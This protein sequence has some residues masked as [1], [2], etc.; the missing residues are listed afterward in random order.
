M[1]RTQCSHLWEAELVS[2]SPCRDFEVHFGFPVP[3]KPLKIIWD[4]CLLLR[5]HKLLWRCDSL[6]GLAGWLL[7][8]W[9]MSE[10]NLVSSTESGNMSSHHIQPRLPGHVSGVIFDFRN[11]TLHLSSIKPGG[12][13][14]QKQICFIKTALC[15][16]T[17][18]LTEK[19]SFS[20]G[21]PADFLQEAAEIP[22][23]SFTSMNSS[24]LTPF[25]RSLCQRTW[26]K[27][28]FPALHSF[29]LCRVRINS[30]CTNHSTSYPTNLRKNF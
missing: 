11:V 17:H 5:V 10:E 23:S 9:E 14:K 3:P 29:L 6:L 12:K 28:A 21:F 24:E 19:S 25:T 13:T 7:H 16:K 20:H 8:K 4:N 30:S 18:T 2:G 1:S 22:C 26:Q 15:N 27:G